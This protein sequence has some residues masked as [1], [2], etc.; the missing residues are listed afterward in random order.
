MN[1]T[2]DANIHNTSLR[3]IVETDYKTLVAVFGQPTTGPDALS[4]N[5]KV[6][7]EWDLE[8]EDGVIATIYDWHE[9]FTCF[10]KYPWHIGGHSQEAEDRVLEMIQTYL[11]EQSN[12]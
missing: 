9:Q 1:F 12:A 10:T 4:Y 3:G 6:S 8:F 7:C 5:D 11:K 2:N